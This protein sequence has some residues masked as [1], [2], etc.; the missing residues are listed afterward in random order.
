MKKLNQI[1][2]GE[3]E[4]HISDSIWMYGGCSAFII[5]TFTVFLITL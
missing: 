2:F 5:T 4:I 3:G 1:F